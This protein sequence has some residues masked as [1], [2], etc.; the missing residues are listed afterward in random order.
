[1][2]KYY[3]I[4]GL[5]LSIYNDFFKNVKLTPCV[6]VQVYTYYNKRYYKK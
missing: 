6:T 3:K 1:M 5:I 2:A 4:C